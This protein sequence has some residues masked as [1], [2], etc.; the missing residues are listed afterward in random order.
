MFNSKILEHQQHRHQHLVV[1]T[2]RQHLRQVAWVALALV[3]SVQTQQQP[4]QVNLV[5]INV[6]FCVAFFMII[7]LYFV[8]HQLRSVDLERHWVALELHRQRQPHHFHSIH[9]R[10][11]HQQLHQLVTLADLAQVSVNSG[12]KWFFS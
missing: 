10:L 11:E 8:Q 2:Q 12:S 4:H 9:R 7:F 1:L 5:S 6:S 3:V